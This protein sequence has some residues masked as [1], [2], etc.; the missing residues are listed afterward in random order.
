MQV[1]YKYRKYYF[2]KERGILFMLILP[3]IT[4]VQ[5]PFMILAPFFEIVAIYTL[6]SN[7]MLVIKYFTYFL[8][9]A[10][11]FNIIAFVLARE[12]RVWL[13]LLT[14]LTRIY[15]QYLWYIVLAKSLYAIVKGGYYPWNKMKHTGSVEL[16]YSS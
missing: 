7:P 12:R 16:Q 11:A 8:L 4:L 10:L 2:K 1:M 9:I 6:L 13:L 15:Y 3:F 14:P 5:F